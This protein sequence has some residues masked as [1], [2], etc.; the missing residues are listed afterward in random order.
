MNELMTRCDAP[1][2]PKGEKYAETLYEFL[3]SHRESCGDNE[4]LNVRKIKRLLLI[5]TS[6]HWVN[7]KVWTSPRQRSSGT[8]TFFVE[9][10][11]IVSQNASLV[12]INPGVVDGLTED[13]VA[14][15]YPEE[16]ARHQKDPYNHR[17][18]RAESYH[19]LA[20]RLEDVL[21]ELER[22]KDDVLIIAHESVMRCIYA[23]LM[24]RPEQV[25]VP[26]ST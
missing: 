1:L 14:Q 19:D 22:E 20:L 26:L 12:E 16:F 10:D 21:L 17:Y 4:I 7:A 25:T 23:Y 15:K 13:Q 8:A 18:S 24:D 11:S 6:I 5:R 2:S 3:L 9:S